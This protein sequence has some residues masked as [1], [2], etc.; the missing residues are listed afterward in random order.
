MFIV[1]SKNEHIPD[2]ILSELVRVSVCNKTKERWIFETDILSKEVQAFL[3]NQKERFGKM[4]VFLNEMR[5]ISN[6]I[7]RA[8]ISKRSELDNVFYNEKLSEMEPINKDPSELKIMLFP[9]GDDSF[10]RKVWDTV[11][12]L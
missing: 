8:M 12:M 4:I 9:H 3:S 6:E 1:V 10:E 5:T 7:P 11:A 2:N